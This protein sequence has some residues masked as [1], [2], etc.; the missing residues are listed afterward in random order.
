MEP[1]AIVGLSFKLPQEAED[2]AGFWSILENGKNV[3][4]EWPKGRGNVDAFYTQDTSKDNTVS[5]VCGRVRRM[6][7]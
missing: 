2:E 3:M 1:I 6:D 7:D 4:T 5:L